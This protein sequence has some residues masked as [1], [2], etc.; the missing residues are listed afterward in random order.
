M[1]LFFKLFR[2]LK[3]DL[4]FSQ[5]SGMTNAYFIP[6]RIRVVYLN[7]AFK[8]LIYF[9]LKDSFFLLA[10]KAV[11]GSYRFIYTFKF[12]CRDRID[13]LAT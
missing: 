5:I 8:N 6:Y 9:I 11:K 13:F 3:S 1:Y 12:S 10:K 7:L 4:I 2:N